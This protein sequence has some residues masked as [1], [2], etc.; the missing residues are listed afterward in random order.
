LCLAVAGNTD[1]GQRVLAPALR[2]CATLGLRRLLIDEGP[3]MLRLAKDTVVA[4]ELTSADPK[5]SESVR[6]FVLGLGETSTI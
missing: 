2:T 3:Q 1:E 5:T 6:D 4:D